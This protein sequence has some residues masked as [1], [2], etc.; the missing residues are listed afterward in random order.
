[1][2][3]LNLKKPLS[4]TQVGKDP[5]N[6]SDDALRALARSIGRM[7]PDKVEFFL[8][9]RKY[10][11]EIELRTESFYSQYNLTAGRFHILLFLRCSPELSLSPSELAEKTGVSR[12]TMTQFL[13]ALEKS[14]Y[15]VRE[16]CPG[17]RRATL[18]RI[19]PQGLKT[20]DREILP[21]FFKRCGLFSS[22][23]TK[24]E[25]KLFASIYEKILKNLD[26]SEGF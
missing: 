2:G 12:A 10:K 8:L 25:M 18:I 9:I 22:D 19:S 14:N 5:V 17:D 16:D 21:V 6:P 3:R 15:I 26:R 20:M 7:D 1:M 23:C 24:A 4:E 13:D 11:S